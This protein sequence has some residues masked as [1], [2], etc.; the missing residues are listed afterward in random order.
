ML[1]LKQ[2]QSGFTI[3]ELLIVIV[4]IGILAGLVITTF[5][6]IQARGRDS[7][8]QTDIKAIQ[9]QLEAYFAN[10]GGYPVLAD[11]NDSTW[12]ANNKFTL[13]A[14]ALADPK[15]AATQSVVGTATT[16]RY[17]YTTSVN[18]TASTTCLSPTDAA[19]PP[20]NQTGTICN[21]FNLSVVSEVDATKTFSAAS[22]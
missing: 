21:G 15:T 4:I 7:E 14:K 9:G 18:G 13:D 1:S 6:G 17:L 3:V 22:Q 12:R 10:N 5:V 20:A 19:N 2:K 8:R 11:L 16:N